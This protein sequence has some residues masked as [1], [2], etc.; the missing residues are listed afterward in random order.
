MKPVPEREE[1]KRAGERYYWTGKPCRSGH[2]SKRYTGTGNCA[3]CAVR[4]T[5]AYQAK[6]PDHPN[7]IAARQ[8][9]LKHYSTG[10]PCKWGHDL[11]YVSNGVCVEC[12]AE[13]NARYHA[14]NPGLGAKWARE[15]RAKDPT[16][17]RKA[18]IKWIKGNPEK[19][20][21]I[22]QRMIDKDPELWRKKVLAAAHN[23]NAKKRANGGTFTAADI[24]NLFGKQGGRCAACSKKGKLE[25]DHIVA[26][27]VGGSI[28]PS[29]LQ[30]LCPKCNKSKG[31]K[32]A[33]DWARENGKLL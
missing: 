31:K 33:I 20:K 12:D 29:N 24:E 16:G 28:Y 22:R 30:L 11:R 25:I 7:R 21:V 14:V 32:D 8:S 3:E 18:A 27:A 1:A 26:I 10:A 17:H 2:L 9:G 4:N 5:L 23:Y 6:V 13:K 15:R 19:A